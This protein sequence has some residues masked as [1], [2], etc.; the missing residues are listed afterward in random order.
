MALAQSAM[1]LMDNTR[2]HET[3]ILV[4]RPLELWSPAYLIT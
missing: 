3:K 1:P 2:F 4:L